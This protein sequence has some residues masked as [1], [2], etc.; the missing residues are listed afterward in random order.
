MKLNKIFKVCVFFEDN[1]RKEKESEDFE[2]K[3]V[4]AGNLMAK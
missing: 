4:S 2:S 3:V 1:N